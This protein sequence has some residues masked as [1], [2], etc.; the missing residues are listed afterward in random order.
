MYHVG[1]LSTRFNSP[2]VLAYHTP[3]FL[4]PVKPTYLHNT[5]VTPT[6]RNVV[7]TTFHSFTGATIDPPDVFDNC[8]YPSSIRDCKSTVYDYNLPQLLV[9]I[10]GVY[11][12][13]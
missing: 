5:L 1:V 8:T 10:M 11:L 12:P 3:L 2:T 7:F 9:F 4:T 6:W 13:V